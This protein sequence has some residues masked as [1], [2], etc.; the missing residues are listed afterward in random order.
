MSRLHTCHGDQIH[1]SN[2]RIPKADSRALRTSRVFVH[3]FVSGCVMRTRRAFANTCVRVH[4]SWLHVHHLLQTPRTQNQQFYRGMIQT[5]LSSVQIG[6]CRGFW[7]VDS[8]STVA[9]G[10]FITQAFE[11]NLGA[12]CDRSDKVASGVSRE[13]VRFSSAYWLRL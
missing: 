7:T 4:S 2:S 11:R 3:H 10:A 13:I 1:A 12:F 9:P 6:T 5:Q 8:I